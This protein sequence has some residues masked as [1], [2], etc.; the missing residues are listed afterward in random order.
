MKKVC[1]VFIILFCLGF[2][3][4]ASEGKKGLCVSGGATGSYM[5]F[6]TYENIAFRQAFNN[7]MGFGY[8]VG[9]RLMENYLFDPYLYYCPYIQW[10]S[11][12][13]YLGAGYFF[14]VS[15][16]NDE[17][18]GALLRIGATVLPFELGGGEARIDIG[19]EFSQTAYF[20]PYC[21]YPG[22]KILKEN[23]A[24]FANAIKLCVGLN[25]F[26]PL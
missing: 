21:K 19:F 22:S 4:F 1:A 20:D 12:W 2:S 25:W 23:K 18:K 26:L 14:P 6:F 13:F 16:A 10:D 3:V 24:R 8:E 7:R 5:T 17:T 9:I 11:N 15:F